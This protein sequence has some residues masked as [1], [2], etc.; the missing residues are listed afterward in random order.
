MT[1]HEHDPRAV[2]ALG[3][4]VFD[5]MYPGAKWA[6]V[7]KADHCLVAPVVRVIL[8]REAALKADA[9]RLVAALEV[10]VS[11]HAISCHCALCK[12]CRDAL[13]AHRASRQP[14]EPTL[15]EAVE[16]LFAPVPGPPYPVTTGT[17][18]PTLVDSDKLE[19]VRRALAREQA[20]P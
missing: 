17:I 5:A 7:G 14:S 6:N 15:R 4:E 18:M 20:K 1:A 2:E 13:R 8:T 11:F 12:S 10:A 16:A 19:A 9:E 3:V